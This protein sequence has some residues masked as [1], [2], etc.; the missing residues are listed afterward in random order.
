MKTFILNSDVDNFII[1]CIVMATA[2]MFV[3]KWVKEKL[4]SRK[5]LLEKFLDKEI[6]DQLDNY[7]FNFEN[8]TP[9]EKTLD[10]K[11]K[12]ISV[13]ISLVIVVV[14]LYE[15]IETLKPGVFYYGWSCF[16]NF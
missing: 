9:V 1:T 8:K 11:T 7:T 16:P 3:L 4:E 2:M 10:F 5:P 12:L 13:L 14:P 15:V 6:E